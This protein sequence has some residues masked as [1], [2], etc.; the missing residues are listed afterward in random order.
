MRKRRPPDGHAQL[1]HARK[2]RLSSVSRLILLGKKHLLRRAFGGSP[3]LDP[4]LQR[5]QL[6]RLERARM[7]ALQ[8]AK[9]RLD[10]QVGINLQKSLDL[11]PHVSKRILART[12][13]VR[14]LRL[15]WQ[16]AQP[17]VL[18]RGSLAHAG[19]RRCCRYGLSLLQYQP[20]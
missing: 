14:L 10:L 1:V 11:L 7:P 12:P 2:V 13:R 20:A 17:H 6:T 8:L 9:K 18:A 19:L 5:A 4:P 15:A 16:L 3:L